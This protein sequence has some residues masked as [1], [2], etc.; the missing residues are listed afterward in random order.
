MDGRCNF[1][2]SL[3]SDGTLVARF[4]RDVYKLS[5]IKKAA[6]K[7]GGLFF[8][9]IEES[10]KFTEVSLKPTSTCQNPDEAAGQFCN[11]VLDQELREEIAAETKGVRD[12]LLAHAFSKTSLIDSEMETADYNSVLDSNTFGNSGM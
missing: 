11:E 1:A 9:L 3:T 2:V 4:D 8:I 6:Y 12:L 5:A 10:E 7:Y